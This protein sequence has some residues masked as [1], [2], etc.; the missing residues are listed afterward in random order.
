MLSGMYSI[1]KI[2]YKSLGLFNL[3]LFITIRMMYYQII[4]RFK[5]RESWLSKNTSKNLFMK[6]LKSI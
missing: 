4:L 1:I 6:M 2:L 5:K 3:K